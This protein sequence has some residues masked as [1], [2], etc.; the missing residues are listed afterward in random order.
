MFLIPFWFNCKFIFVEKYVITENEIF[1]ILSLYIT[2]FDRMIPGYP[3]Y[4][5]EG[6][7]EDGV[8]D[9]RIENAQLEDDGEFQCQ[10]RLMNFF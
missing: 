6:S 5:M 2:G 10:V 8:H 1:Y 9:L 3:R 7:G 4:F